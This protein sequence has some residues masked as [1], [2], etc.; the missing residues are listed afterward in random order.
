MKLLESVSREEHIYFIVALVGFDPRP[1]LQPL[2]VL[3]LHAL[4]L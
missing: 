3:G 2:R 4:E 1:P